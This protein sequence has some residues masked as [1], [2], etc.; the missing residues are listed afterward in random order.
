MSQDVR[1]LQ[2]DAPEQSLDFFETLSP[3]IPIPDRYNIVPSWYERHRDPQHTTVTKDGTPIPP[4][5]TVSQVA[6]EFRWAIQEDG[7]VLGQ[8]EFQEAHARWYNA[9][10]QFAGQAPD[11]ANLRSVPRVERFVT[12]QV[13]PHDPSRLIPIVARPEG[14][15]PQ[16]QPVYNANGDLIEEM[17]E[18]EK[19]AGYTI[20][21]PEKIEPPVPVEEQLAEPTKSAEELRRESIIAQGKDPDFRTPCGKEYPAGKQYLKQ[22]TRHCKAPECNTEE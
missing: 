20:K 1:S 11:D 6:P 12:R 22:H 2:T 16:I 19:P 8:L 17:G 18:V 15:A 14:P 7:E 5:F 3:A 9:Q 21:R 10:Y 4:G 13:D